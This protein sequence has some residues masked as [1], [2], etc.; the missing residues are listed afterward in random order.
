MDLINKNKHLNIFNYYRSEKNTP[1]E[2]NLSRAFAITLDKN[3]EFLNKIFKKFIF[4]DVYSSMF[5]LDYDLIK[6]NNIYIGI[7]S[8]IAGSGAVLFTALLVAISL[9]FTD[10]AFTEIAKMAVFS[11]LPLMIIEGIIS[12]FVIMFIKKVKPEIIKEEE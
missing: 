6:E 9:N 7:V 11:H 1:K 12:I 8:F 4:N 2:D 10:Q 3:R 5:S